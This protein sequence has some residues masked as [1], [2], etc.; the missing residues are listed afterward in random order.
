MSVTGR[1]MYREIGG[2]EIGFVYIK[3]VVYIYRA[4]HGGIIK[5]KYTHVSGYRV[6]YTFSILLVHFGFHRMV[7]PSIHFFRQ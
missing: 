1:S 7:Y 5:H 6:R 3:S 4:G 2:K